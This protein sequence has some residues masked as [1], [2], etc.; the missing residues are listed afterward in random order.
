M[1]LY[2]ALIFLWAKLVGATSA[3][4]CS[5]FDILRIPALHS[6]KRNNSGFDTTL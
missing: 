1:F 3:T 2:N 4:S 6:E 5:M